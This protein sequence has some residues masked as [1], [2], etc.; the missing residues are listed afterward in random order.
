MKTKENTQQTNYRKSDSDIKTV[1]IHS[2]IEKTGQTFRLVNELN[3]QVK[4]LTSII[5]TFQKQINEIHVLHFSGK[6]IQD[7][8]HL[9]KIPCRNSHG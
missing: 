3:D 4:S 9:K 1:D 7:P 8:D 5:E 6:H 2:L